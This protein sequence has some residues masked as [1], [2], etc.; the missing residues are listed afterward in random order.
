MRE[1]IGA[2]FDNA[3]GL[4]NLW[5]FRRRLD[6]FKRTICPK[7]SECDRQIPQR[8]GNPSRFTP[9]EQLPSVRSGLVRVPLGM[10]LDKPPCSFLINFVRNFIGKLG[11]RVEDATCAFAHGASVD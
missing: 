2:G 7:I 9:S 6:F 3:S 11:L 8:F 1:R 10:A 4:V 5:R